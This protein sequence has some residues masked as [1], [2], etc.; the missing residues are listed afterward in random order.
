[1]SHWFMWFS[2]MIFIN[3][4]S[5]IFAFCQPQLPLLGGW[6]LHPN[7]FWKFRFR[8]HHLYT[9]YLYN[10]SRFSHLRTKINLS[11]FIM[12]PTFTIGYSSSCPMAVYLCRKDSYL[13]P[14]F[15][16]WRLKQSVL[17]NFLNPLST[18]RAYIHAQKEHT[19]LVYSPVKQKD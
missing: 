9:I 18:M 3:L 11:M 16:N 1:M 19:D 12:F 15:Y 17:V 2:L 7:I 6:I 4:S 8:N 10:I 5:H 13:F 14:L